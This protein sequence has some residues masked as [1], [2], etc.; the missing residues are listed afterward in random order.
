M[1]LCTNGS[2]VI[3]M[4]HDTEWNDNAKYADHPGVTH[5]FRVSPRS[6]SADSLFGSA[7][8]EKSMS[9]DDVVSI[10]IEEVPFSVEYT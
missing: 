1:I 4:Y 9:H 6:V 5:A 2:E 10:A 3:S 7:H 8:E